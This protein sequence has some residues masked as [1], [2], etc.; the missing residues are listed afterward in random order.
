MA[1]RYS[2]ALPSPPSN[3][4]NDSPASIPNLTPTPISSYSYPYPAPIPAH[5]HERSKPPTPVQLYN[6]MPK[7]LS[8][9]G[10]LSSLRRTGTTPPPAI[11][12]SA[13]SPLRN[14]PSLRRVPH[15][16]SAMRPPGTGPPPTSY[17]EPLV[18]EPP[19]LPPDT[20]LQRLGR[21]I[22]KPP[23][24]VDT[25]PPSDHHRTTDHARRTSG[26]NNHHEREIPHDPLPGASL[27]GLLPSMGRGRRP[28]RPT[29]TVPSSSDEESVTASFSNYPGRMQEPA[30]ARV[31]VPLVGEEVP[32]NGGFIDDTTSIRQTSP[33]SHHGPSAMEVIDRQIQQQVRANANANAPYGDLRGAAGVM[34]PI[35]EMYEPSDDATIPENPA[36]DRI[37]S[38]YAPSPVSEHDAAAAAQTSPPTTKPRGAVRFRLAGLAIQAAQ[39]MSAGTANLARRGSLGSGSGSRR[40]STATAAQQSPHDSPLRVT[41]TRRITNP[42]PPAPE[43]PPLATR[44]H[45]GPGGVFAPDPE[46]PNPVVRTLLERAASSQRRPAGW[47]APTVETLS[48]SSGRARSSGSSQAVHVREQPRRPPPPRQQQQQ[49]MRTSST[50]HP[51][52]YAYRDRAPVRER[53]EG[54]DDGYSNGVLSGD[55]VPMSASSPISDEISPASGDVHRSSSQQRQYPLYRDPSYRVTGSRLRDPRQ[56]PSSISHEGPTTEDMS[57]AHTYESSRPLV[58]KGNPPPTKPTRA[59]RR[60]RGGQFQRNA[61]GMEIFAEP[62]FEDSEDPA[63]KRLSYVREPSDWEPIF[64]ARRMFREVLY[65]PFRSKKHPTV[66]YI[67]A[68]SKPEDV[69][70][71]A[72]QQWYVPRPNSRRVHATPAAVIPGGVQLVDTRPGPPR[73]RDKRAPPGPA[74][75]SRWRL[76]KKRSTV[77]SHTQPQPILHVVE[78]DPTH[79]ARYMTQDRITAGQPIQ[80]LS[81]DAPPRL[82]S[83]GPPAPA[84]AYFSPTSSNVGGSPS[85]TW[86]THAPA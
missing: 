39:R 50:T 10:S 44:L 33:R 1:S 61:V 59:L 46:P 9:G 37:L 79:H 70:T 63:R 55:D 84:P 17:Q 65:L 86:F 47:M 71:P 68:R 12:I 25:T 35:G 48:S 76:R 74:V 69:P 20:R 3:H 23:P 8:R 18:P 57:H 13:P 80:V 36:L 38:P 19:A 75:S 29:G 21:V 27:G 22:R 72:V 58:A 51:R 30:T 64:A 4:S 78:Q 56:G 5:Y 81:E 42:K 6:A 24:R 43:Q 77:Y 41:L 82:V 40:Q 11:S 54:S 34:S 2:K 67:P 60:R 85:S 14:S 7:P 49:P 45:A 15:S 28:R 16:V 73:R 62:I 32:S 31:P 26:S 53:R 83:T 52:S 66:T